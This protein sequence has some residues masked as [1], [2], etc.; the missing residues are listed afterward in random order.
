VPHVFE[1]YRGAHE[2]SL[3]VRHAATWLGLALDHLAQA[4]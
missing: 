3:W 4:R 1:L 2:Q